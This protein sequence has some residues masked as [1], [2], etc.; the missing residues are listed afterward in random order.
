[1]NNQW[2]VESFAEIGKVGWVADT[3]RGYQE[4]HFGCD[5]PELSLRIKMEMKR[6]CLPMCI[7]S[8]E[9]SLKMASE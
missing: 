9:E 8:L 2:N 6:N 7:L 4:L 3:F 5:K 1:M